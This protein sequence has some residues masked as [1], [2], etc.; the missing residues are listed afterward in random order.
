MS[1]II[2]KV[3]PPGEGKT[4]WLV[5]NA[6]VEYCNGK[7][8]YFLCFSSNVTAYQDFCDMYM[9]YYNKVCPVL[10]LDMTEDINENTCVFIDEGMSN[11]LIG[12]I[13]KNL[14]SRCDKIYITLEGFTNNPDISLNHADVDSN[15]LSIF[16][17]INKE[18]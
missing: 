10:I 16:D 17:S 12:S 6:N 15:Q 7:T 8:C 14:K 3:A 5:D 1:K 9:A 13:V 2:Y 4:K 18:D 11:E